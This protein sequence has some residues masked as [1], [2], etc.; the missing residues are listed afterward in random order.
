MLCF[1]LIFFFDVIFLLMLVFCYHLNVT[2]CLQF[3]FNFLVFVDQALLT[4]EPVS[5]TIV[6]PASPTSSCWFCGFFPKIVYR[7]TFLHLLLHGGA[8]ML[9]VLFSHLVG[10]FS[11]ELLQWMDMNDATSFRIKLIFWIL[12]RNCQIHF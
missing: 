11:V 2:F 5:H 1:E 7:D 4:A 8:H 12:F 3:A 6:L 10:R 9:S